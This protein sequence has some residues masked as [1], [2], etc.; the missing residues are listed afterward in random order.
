[1][2]FGAISDIDG[3]LLLCTA[4]W[5]GIAVSTWF[6][7]LLVVGDVYAPMPSKYLF[8]NSLGSRID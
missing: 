5:C 1:M 6:S 3:S 7:Q 4:A 8:W 2:E